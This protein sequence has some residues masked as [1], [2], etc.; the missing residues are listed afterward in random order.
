MKDGGIRSEDIRR[1]HHWLGM[2]VEEQFE[3]SLAKDVEASER[4][5]SV[6][7]HRARPWGTVDSRA[8]LDGTMLRE[9]SWSADVEML[10][11]C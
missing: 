3:R 5:D 10:A 6:N 9:V 7:S 2:I 8:R 4:S 1:T 11:R